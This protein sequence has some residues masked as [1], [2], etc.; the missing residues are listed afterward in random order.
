MAQVNV[1]VEQIKRILGERITSSTSMPS[2]REIIL[3]INQGLA[4]VMKGSFFEGAN[5][6]DV[7]YANDQFNITIT[8]I[9]VAS[10]S[11]HRI[12]TLPKMPIELPRSR[13]IVSVRPAGTFVNAYDPI[14]RKDLDIMYG[15]TRNREKRRVVYFQEN[16]EIHFHLFGGA[17]MGNTVDI[18]LVAPGNITAGA[19]LNVSPDVEA[20]IIEYVVKVLGRTERDPEDLNTDG[21]DV[22]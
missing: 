15:H 9:S 18:T 14:L 5:I 7:L 3:H 10:G 22:R 17:T 4:Y 20:K 2:T 13:G 21:I 1:I 11:V 8:G 12:A 19:M 16:I 6:D